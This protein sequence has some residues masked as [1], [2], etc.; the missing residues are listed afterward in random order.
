MSATGQTTASPTV[1]ERVAEVIASLPR[2]TPHAMEATLRRPGA[3][4][5]TTKRFSAF[6]AAAP[7]A[8]VPMKKM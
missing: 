2:T 4:A 6:S 3:N 5:V 1:A 8:A 7:S